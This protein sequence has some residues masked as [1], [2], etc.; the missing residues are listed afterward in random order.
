MKKI[1]KSTVTSFLVFW[2]AACSNTD[3]PEI[4]P[5]RFKNFMNIYFH[6]YIYEYK[7]IN[8]RGNHNYG[9]QYALFEIKKIDLDQGEMKLI[10]NQ[11]AQNGWRVIES[12]DKNFI[13]FCYGNNFSLDILFPLKKYEVT[14]SGVPIKFNEM[15]NWNIFLY[16]STTTIA[17]CS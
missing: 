2:L 6:G 10:F 11:L 16:K 5:D 9:E 7:D 15:D 8:A 17:A 4:I 3:K 13:S 12:N 1:I 14:P